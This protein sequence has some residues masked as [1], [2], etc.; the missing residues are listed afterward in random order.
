[1]P[2]VTDLTDLYGN[3]M[4]AP[5]PGP[6]VCEICFDF[7]GGVSRCRWC[8]ETD[9]WLDAVAPI[10]YSIA[11]EQLHHALAGYKRPPD[12][13]AERFQ[14]ELAAVL[15]RYLENHEPCIADAA[16]TDHFDRITTVPSSTRAR[17]ASH[18]I[19]RIA[20]ELV[21]PSRRRYARIL[22][23][24]QAK[25]Q[26]RELHLD[27]FEAI[28]NLEGQSVLL[29]DDTWT[30]GA[31]ARSAAAALK[32]AGAKTVAAVVIGRYL[33]RDWSDNDRRLNALS[34]PFDWQT[35]AHRTSDSAA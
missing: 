32:G 7:T 28:S 15:W 30:T 3:F 19:H 21:L 6:G 24:S 13:A 34:S 26:P 16:L 5:R 29:I 14:L 18:P 8:P 22:Q 10:S 27:K 23:R 25:T 35:C 1:M 9:P 2:R 20:G 33:K 12:V 11:H 4:L 31:N 17:D